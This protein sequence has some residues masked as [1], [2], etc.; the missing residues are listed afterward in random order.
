MA[1]ESSDVR[2]AR[3]EEGV[4]ALD[5]KISLYLD[6]HKA[7]MERTKERVMTNEVDISLFKRDRTWLMF[8]C[9]ILGGSASLAVEYFC[10]IKS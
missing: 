3:I 7:D 10:R 1:K 2:L 8:I 6:D 4:K 5:E 9:T